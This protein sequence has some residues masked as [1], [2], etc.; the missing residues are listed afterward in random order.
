MKEKWKRFKHWLIRKLGGHPTEIT[1]QIVHTH[2]PVVT[3][4][5]FIT[6]TQFLVGMD[7]PEEYVIECLMHNL[8]NELRPLV[9]IDHCENPM[10]GTITYRAR[11]Q[12]ADKRGR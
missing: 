8:A 3:I 11:I 9:Q 6:D 12:V 10:D 1:A 5:A 4:E 7:K 2:V